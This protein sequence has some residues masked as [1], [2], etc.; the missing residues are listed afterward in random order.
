MNRISST[1][2]T[3]IAF[4]IDTS[5]MAATYIYYTGREI[6]PIGGYRGGIPSPT[7]T[8]LKQ[9]VTSGELRAFLIPTEPPSE[10]HRIVWVRNHCKQAQPL[11]RGDHVQLA[12]Y[13]C[14]PHP[15]RQADRRVSPASFQ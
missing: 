13:D 14:S 9:Y 15:E 3:P 12:I 7:L 4:A 1:Y 11:P 5:F 2:H 8:R 6:L 10:D